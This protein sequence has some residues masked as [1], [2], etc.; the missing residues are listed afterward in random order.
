[1]GGDSF[2]A[3]DRTA[4]PLSTLPDSIEERKLIC[5]ELVGSMEDTRILLALFGAIYAGQEQDYAKTFE[6]CQT[7]TGIGGTNFWESQFDNSPFGSVLNLT[8]CAIR[9]RT[10][11]GG[12]LGSN[13]FDVVVVN[14]LSSLCSYWDYRATRESVQFESD[15]GRRTLLLPASLLENRHA[16]EAMVEFIRLHLPYPNVSTNLHV[17]FCVWD[18][19]D[20]ERLQGAIADINGFKQFSEDTISV[21]HSWNKDEPLRVED[22]ST[23]PITY[24]VHF[25][26][27][28]QSYLEGIGNEVA[29]DVELREGGNEILFEP[30]KGYHNRFGGGVALDLECDIWQRF[31]KTQS[32]AQRIKDGSWLSRYGLTSVTGISARPQYINFNIPSEREALEL[33]FG[34]RGYQLRVSKP[35]EYATAVVNL[36]GGLSGMDVVASRPVYLLLDILALKSTKKLAQRI[37]K[38]AAQQGIQMSVDSIVDIQRLLEDVEIVPELKR[39]PKT[40]RQLCDIAELLPYRKDL[41]AHLARL[42][43]RQIIKRGFHLQCP[44]CGTPAWYPLAIIEETVV[45]PGCSHRFPLPVEQPAT[46]EIQWEYTLNTLVNRAMDQDAL[47]SVFALRHLTKD[48]QASCLVPGLELLQSGKVKAELDFVFV[49]EQDVFAGECKAGDTLGDKDIATARF[50]ANLGIKTFYCCTVAVFDDASKQRIQAVRDEL[51]G[52]RTAMAIEVLEGDALL[53][54]V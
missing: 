7:P 47:V 50:A 45:C 38:Q 6:L 31:A 10:V 13:H 15:M 41:L 42:S 12:G 9:P 23:K 16:L 1:M 51:V 52:N 35:G 24:L 17:R 34:G 14:S 22:F 49:S 46:N 2:E 8:G 5:H 27:F 39:I 32:I 53:A 44:N 28:P 26:D 54:R 19:T 20:H 3:W 29:R 11:T 48:R 25:P 18:Q 4:H 37:V 33:I 21:R 30:P 43:E 36:V 40:Y